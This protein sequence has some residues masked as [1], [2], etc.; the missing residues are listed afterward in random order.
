[1]TQASEQR[2]LS[3][4]DGLAGERVDAAIA[5]MFGVS[6]TRAADLI[7]GG[8][9]RLDGHDGS[10]CTHL[11]VG[12]ALPSSATWPEQASASPPAARPSGRA[13]SSASTWARPE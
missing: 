9:V 5:R 13:S 11:R 4:P 8:L 6:R 3:V 7:A 1:M 10:P 12:A 2:T